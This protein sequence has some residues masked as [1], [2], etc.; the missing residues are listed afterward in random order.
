MSGAIHP[1]KK[2]REIYQPNGK[3]IPKGSKVTG[4]TTENRFDAVKESNMSWGQKK[5]EILISQAFQSTKWKRQL[6]SKPGE[7]TFV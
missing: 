6:Y 1:P 2:T 5:E 3:K 4:Y 7:K